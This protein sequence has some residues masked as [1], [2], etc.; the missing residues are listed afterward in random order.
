MVDLTPAAIGLLETG[1]WA[2]ALFVLF[3]K[4]G[5]TWAE[6][7]SYA[8]F[9][10]C[11][12]FS[13]TFQ[14]FFLV[15][16]PALSPAAEALIT[17]AALAALIRRKKTAI[18]A[19]II[20]KK[21]VAANPAASALATIGLVYLAALA[22]VQPPSPDHWPELLRVLLMERAAEGL[23]GSAGKF[24]PLN[25][26]ILPHLFL[27]ASTDY[28]VGLFGLTGFLVILFSTYALA[29]RFSWPPTALA[30]S[31]VMLG[32]PRL[33]FL[34]SSPGLE[35]LSAA[36]ALFCLLALFRLV[37]QPSALDLFLLVN[38][39]LFVQ[40]GLPLCLVWQ[41]ILFILA[42]VVLNRRHGP[43]FWRPMILDR[44]PLY[45]V[46]SLVPA[47]VFSQIPAGLKTLAVGRSW[48]GFPGFGDFPYNQD[49]LMGA[50]ANFVRYF[51]ESLHLTRLVDYLVEHLLHFSPQILVQKTYNLLLTP[52]FGELGQGYPFHVWWFP[53]GRWA[54]FG[55]LGF[56]LILPSLVYAAVRGNRRIKALAAA[57]WGYYYL[58]AL[59]PAWEPG[60][61][62]LFTVFYTCS[63]FLTAFFLSPWRITSKGRKRLTGLSLLL[64]FYALLANADKPILDFPTPAPGQSHSGVFDR[65]AWENAV[66]NS[67]WLRSDWGRDRMVQAEKYFGDD[68]VSRLARL[69]PEGREV[70]VLA[71]QDASV[72]P[73]MLARPD[74][75]LIIYDAPRPGEQDA[76]LVLFPDQEP[77]LSA[78][79]RQSRIIWT[80]RP[81]GDILPGALIQEKPF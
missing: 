8:L 58:A 76:A 28:G 31:L 56:F 25:Q 19:V 5:L 32:L 3:F 34:A 57:L 26:L 37:E 11:L 78:L 46:V 60:N 66:R 33:V 80:A 12:L 62:S 55:P 21:K 29:R 24:I 14:V 59:I 45:V 81:G 51:F 65:R 48:P 70:A 41:A 49:M 1:L 30:V 10:V 2:S 17:L 44:H 15:G 53:S 77:A 61:A 13:F 69:I 68:R 42:A 43:T 39:I 7:A 9:S 74:L 64:F 38:G 20:F 18:S 52:V 47:L 50:I 6:S 36:S 27:R 73:F 16:M 67:I 79:T 23:P 54:W 40:S 72:Y 4:R 71:G 35:I 63:G 22:L 75:D